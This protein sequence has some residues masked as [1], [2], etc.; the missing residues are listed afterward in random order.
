MNPTLLL[1][2]KHFLLKI[3][4]DKK[5]RKTIICFI[6]GFVLLI[7][8]FI[9]M[10]ISFISLLKQMD[11]DILTLIFNSKISIEYLKKDDI[12]L[13]EE[14]SFYREHLNELEEKAVDI[15]NKIE[16][17][18][19]NE[20]EESEEELPKINILLMKIIY[21]VLFL[22]DKYYLGEFLNLNN[23]DEFLNAFY[24]KETDEIQEEDIEEN[25]I[26]IYAIEELEDT[27]LSLENIFSIKI[28]EE[29]RENID[30]IYKFLLAENE[31][32]NVTGEYAPPVDYAYF[33]SITSPFGNRIDPITG[34][35]SFHNGTDFAWANCYGANIYAVAD[36][37]ILR[38]I[39]VNDG[40][41]ICVVIEHENGIQTY[42]AHTSRTVVTVG[43]KVLKGQKVAEIGSTGRSTGNHLHLGLKVNGTW[44]N[45][46]QLYS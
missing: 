17:L 3:I 7:I 18:Y 37:V 33:N 26:N 1:M 8:F 25:I 23:K 2:L 28:T 40:F 6:V 4:E 39:D 20:E 32:L 14:I 16:D 43:T 38:A 42:Y 9:G 34:V 22:E 21:Y 24:K 30:E 5:T 10:F 29:K 13:Y 27:Y 11:I 15:N 44:R 46:L 12:E 45:P 41:G 31:F 19:K 36:G 35:S